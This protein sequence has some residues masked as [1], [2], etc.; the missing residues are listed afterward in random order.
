MASVVMAMAHEGPVSMSCQH[1]MV[2][3]VK[4]SGHNIRV[5]GVG[6]SVRP[7]SA[8]QIWVWW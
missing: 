2:Q 3:S 1:S 5:T 8:T 6:V 4:T 7:D